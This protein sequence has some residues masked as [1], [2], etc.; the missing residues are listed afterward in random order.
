MTDAARH[1][2]PRPN[3]NHAMNLRI[4]GLGMAYAV[5][6]M[7]EKHAALQR[8][9]EVLLKKSLLPET[10]MREVLDPETLEPLAP[11]ARVE[12]DFFRNELHSQIGMLEGDWD[13][14]NFSAS[15]T[16]IGHLWDSCADGDQFNCNL[17]WFNHAGTIAGSFPVG[18][19][20]PQM[21]RMLH[22][23]LEYGK[24][25]EDYYRYLH[26][27]HEGMLEKL[28]T[29]EG[30]PRAKHEAATARLHGLIRGCLDLQNDYYALH[31]EAVKKRWLKVDKADQVAWELSIGS[32]Q[33]SR[34][35]VSEAVA[36][37]QNQPALTEHEADSREERLQAY[38]TDELENVVAQQEALEVL[39]DNLPPRN[40]ILAQ[41]I[42]N[43]LHRMQDVVTLA[44]EILPP[45]QEEPVESLHGADGL[46]DDVLHQEEDAHE[47]SLSLP[48]PRSERYRNF[49]ERKVALIRLT[50]A[51]QEEILAFCAYDATVRD[52]CDAHE[53]KVNIPLPDVAMTLTQ[54]RVFKEDLLE[55]HDPEML[56]PMYSSQFALQDLLPDHPVTGPVQPSI[57]KEQSAV[58]DQL[59]C[60][61]PPEA[62]DCLGPSQQAYAAAYRTY[63]SRSR[64]F[65]ALDFGEEPSNGTDK[66]RGPAP[67][68]H[69]LQKEYFAK[70]QRKTQ[71][72]Q[73]VHRLQQ[74]CLQA[75]LRFD[76]TAHGGLLTDDERQ[77]IQENIA[78]LEQSFPVSLPKQ[79]VMAPTQARNHIAELDR[80]LDNGA[81][82]LA[83]TRVRL[84]L[85]K[86]DLAPGTAADAAFV[87][88]LAPVT[89][90]LNDLLK[91][92]YLGRRGP[93]SAK[94]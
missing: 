6:R 56:S 47:L 22:L 78:Q 38:L 82:I 64:A 65:R 53:V 39:A 62:S 3:P 92:I 74:E 32:I 25:E 23:G 26:A 44:E 61:L 9:F 59:L 63:Q 54:L 57:P 88:H 34:K 93:G 8:A 37:W 20:T 17:A 28:G 79:W 91:S 18:V 51:K 24:E 70:L 69:Q 60:R 40:N 35:T 94:I 68:T 5:L 41:N 72:M 11:Y 1:S 89:D 86:R 76:Q 77:D 2:H 4:A 73:Q 30:R 84:L 49:L 66:R 46:L 48:P 90:Q 83:H 15:I 7:L 42:S 80:A 19:R 14:R 33:E 43:L 27:L 16:A 21:Q 29:F 85:L 71:Q 67:F 10:A 13:E 52:F 50:E 31:R 81:D 12:L 75:V 55:C 45:P 87:T 36:R 58:L